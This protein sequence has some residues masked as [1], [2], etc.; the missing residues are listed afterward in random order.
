MSAHDVVSGLSCC[1]SVRFCRKRRCTRGRR[2]RCL[3]EVSIQSCTAP[4]AWHKTYVA[5]SSVFLLYLFHLHAK[6][7]TVFLSILAHS[8]AVRDVRWCAGDFR[9]PAQNLRI[10][11]SGGENFQYVYIS[12]KSLSISSTRSLNNCSVLFTGS[13][14]FMSTPASF[15][16]SIGYL[17]VPTVRNLR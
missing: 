7:Y 14:L 16:I 15:R 10:R 9:P 5:T 4:G 3:F 2:L 13:G 12:C 11:L 17:D 8:A 6:Y 1:P